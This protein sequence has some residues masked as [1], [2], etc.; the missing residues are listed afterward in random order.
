MV[1]R[2]SEVEKFLT[3]IGGRCEA[4]ILIETIEAVE[5]AA[6]LALLPLN[7]VY[8]GLNDFAICRGSSFIFDA[9]K[10]GIIERVREQLGKIPFG[11]GGATAIDL[12]APIP[13]RMLLAE[14]AR[15]NCQFTFLRR[16]FKRDIATRDPTTVVTGI[17]DYW[18]GLHNRSPESAASEFQKLLTTVTPLCN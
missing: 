16:S 4:A 3:V 8:F 15:L 10:D 13:C 9:L 11:F 5:L 17:H 2:V 1:R 18:R 12:G 14:M 6:D 7:R